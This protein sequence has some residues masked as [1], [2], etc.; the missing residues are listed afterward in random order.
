MRSRYVVMITVI[1]F[2]LVVVGVTIVKSDERGGKTEKREGRRERSE[3]EEVVGRVA[4]LEKEIA[5]LRTILSNVGT[6]SNRAIN[7]PLSGPRVWTEGTRGWAENGTNIW[8]S[9][10]P[11][12]LYNVGIGTTTPAYKLDVAGNIRADAGALTNVLIRANCS[13]NPAWDYAGIALTNGTFFPTTRLQVFG[14]AHSP[15]NEFHIRHYPNAP[16]VFTTNNTERMRISGSGDVGI[17]TTNPQKKLHVN[18]DARFE[19]IWI[20]DTPI[21][22]IAFGASA[23][24]GF[25]QYMD[26]SID[27]VAK[28]GRDI[29]LGTNNSYDDVVIDTD[30]DVGI[31]TNSPSEKLHVIGNVQADD[32]L[33]NSSREYKENIT[34]LTL[35]EAIEAVGKL[36]PVTYYYK[37]HKDERCVGFIAEDVPQLVAMNDRKGLSPMD[38]VAVLTRV[39]QNQQN[40]IEELRKKISTVYSIIELEKK[41]TEKTQKSYK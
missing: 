21:P 1:I 34:E 6:I 29:R 23:E 32:Y 8:T 4:E 26:F 33:Y 35:K 15:P 20:T 28:T 17:G 41:Q 37:T 39:V 31:G 27:I 22:T 24:H 5:E 13:N 30:G 10:A 3:V 16:I 38:I 18:G 25:I 9:V 40:D 7:D 19:T 36:K 11:L 2:L 14:P 12:P